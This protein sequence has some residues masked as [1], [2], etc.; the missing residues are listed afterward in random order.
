[1]QWSISTEE[2]T[3]LLK[4]QREHFTLG[5]LSLTYLADVS[6]EVVIALERDAVASV[7]GEGTGEVELLLLHYGDIPQKV[8]EKMKGYVGMLPVQPDETEVVAL[9]VTS[10][11]REILPFSIFWLHFYFE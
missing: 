11:L 4:A 2:E 1:M 10:A 8:R 7:C 9:L 6:E 5:L 3:V